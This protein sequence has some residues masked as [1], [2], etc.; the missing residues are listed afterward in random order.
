MLKNELARTALTKAMQIRSQ[1]NIPLTDSICIY[2]FVENKDIREVR[3]VEIPSMEELY[4]KNEKM[5]LINSLRPMGRQ[6]FNCGH[7]FGHHVFGHGMCLT[8]VA[9]GSSSGKRFDSKE[10]LA[11]CFSDFLLMPKTTVCHGFVSRGWKAESCTPFQVFTIAGWLGV[12][13][14]TLIQHMRDTL[15]LI[16]PAHAEKL[17]K[18]RPI[19]IRTQIFGEK[20]PANIVVVDEQWKGRP[21]DISA[22]DYL[23]LADEL[24]FSG[25]CLKY[26]KKTLFGFIVQGIAPGCDGK[27]WNQKSGWSIQVRGSRPNYVG[28]NIFRFE[29][30]PDYDVN[31][32][33]A[34]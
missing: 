14:G 16:S 10:F 32:V 34:R 7:G 33:L 15:K 21:V 5:I 1:A 6:V 3:F 28:R 13:Y 17:L 9:N 19:Q 8:S 22:G 4:W 24:C 11:D 26:Y 12:G 20:S 30:D 2:D 29:E 25:N 31:T 18:T 27:I 23:L